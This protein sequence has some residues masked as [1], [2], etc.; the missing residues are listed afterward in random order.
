[1]QPSQDT[2][3]RVLTPGAQVTM[4]LLFSADQGFTT[5]CERETQ[6]LYLW[7]VQLKGTIPLGLLWWALFSEASELRRKPAQDRQS[8]P[9]YLKRQFGLR[10]VTTA[11]PPSMKRRF[12]SARETRCCY[13]RQT[14]TLVAMENGLYS[15]CLRLRGG[16]NS[17]TA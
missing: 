8:K 1:M 2:A 17:A 13:L 4:S 11:Q 14:D 3:P 10:P 15:T 5:R 12:G 7:P 9:R 16:Q 6:V